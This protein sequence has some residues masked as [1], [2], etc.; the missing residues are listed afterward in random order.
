M[1]D[2]GITDNN[3]VMIGVASL[4]DPGRYPPEDQLYRRMGNDDRLLADYLDRKNL[5]DGSVLADTFEIKVLWLASSRRKQFVITSDYDFVPALNRPWDFGIKYILVTNPAHSAAQDAI[6]RR[7]PT[8]WADGA[9][10]STLSYSAVG[11][12]GEARWRLYRVDEP[13]TPPDR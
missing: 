6:T 12:A 2:E 5:P 10:I 8:M 4:I 11:P 3:Q 9:G 7:Y 1:L 13:P